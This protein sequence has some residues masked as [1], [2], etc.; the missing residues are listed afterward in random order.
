[1]FVKPGDK[2]SIGDI[3]LE[4]RTTP[5]HT[6]GCVAYV[7]GEEADQPQPR[8]AFTGDAVLIRGCGRTD[9]QEIDGNFAG[10]GTADVAS[11]QS[12]L[13]R[14]IG[15]DI[16]D[17]HYKECLYTGIGVSCVEGEVMPGQWELQV[18]MWRVFVLVIQYVLLD[19]F[20]R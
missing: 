9:F 7:T 15:R 18:Y 16:V 10:V 17:P 19:A 6:T 4:V 2:V 12:T 5:G 1:M 3:Y 20:S 11:S 14:A 8:M 13:E